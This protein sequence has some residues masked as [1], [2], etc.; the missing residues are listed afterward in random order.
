MRVTCKALS[1]LLLYPDE[2]LRREAR[3]LGEALDRDARLGPEARAGLACL[4]DEMASRDLY[5]LQERYVLLFDRTRSLSLHLFEHVHGESRD[6]GQAMV[7]LQQLYESRGFE[8]AARELPDYLPMF[9]EFLSV[10][11]EDEARRTLGDIV[12][13]VAALRQRLESR[14]SVYAGLFAAIESL[15]QAS[16]DKA[17]VDDIL[18]DPDSDPEDLAD[19]DRAWAEE[20][21][22]FGPGASAGACPRVDGMLRKMATPP[23]GAAPVER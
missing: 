10:L 6:R 2:E 21:V 18:A 22:T 13:I 1:L 3:A 16:P 15:A 23:A 9:L 8:I 5:D 19:L 7:D 4:I 14:G 12:H 17:A 11:P 20:P